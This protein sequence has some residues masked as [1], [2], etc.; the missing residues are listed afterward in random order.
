MAALTNLPINILAPM[1]TCL[2]LSHVA[3]QVNIHVVTEPTS[4]VLAT[5]TLSPIFLLSPSPTAGHV[6]AFYHIRGYQSC[7][8]Q[9]FTERKFVII[10]SLIPHWPSAGHVTTQVYIHEVPKLILPF[11][12]YFVVAWLR[13][14]TS[15]V[16]RRNHTRGL[17]PTSPVVAS[18][19]PLH[20]QNTSLTIGMA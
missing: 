7:W 16:T 15:H 12:H 8:L 4:L 13:Y 9:F 18:V 1:P 6:T 19:A 3:T 11:A 17:E 5:V 20:C 14:G 10:S 2:V